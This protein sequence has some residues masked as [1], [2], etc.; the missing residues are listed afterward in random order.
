MRYSLLKIAGCLT[1]F[2]SGRAVAAGLLGV[3]ILTSG[4]GTTGVSKNRMEKYRPE[5]DRVWLGSQQVHGDGSA[6]ETSVAPVRPAEGA[7][8]ALRKGDRLLIYL[9]GIP[10]PEDI[11]DVI[12]DVGS[13]NLP[14]I[15]NMRIAGRTTSEAESLIESA[16]V[17]DGY[18]T[19]INV[20][21]VAQEDEYFVRG[22]VKAEGRYPMYG[23]LTLVQAV[24]SAGGY[25][26]YANR[27]KIKIIRGEQS[28]VFDATKIEKQ[29]V[30]DPLVKP[31]DIIVV[32]RRFVW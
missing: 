11:R 3:M 5:V 2:G 4:C 13:V 29:E 32:P 7:S 30:S 10:E 8:A 28:L 22:E 14:F 18:Y 23:D 26:D 17:K 9:R 24:T 16:Y 19:K 25:T 31:G 6:R 1:G 21:I 12:D 15:G 20:I 27:R